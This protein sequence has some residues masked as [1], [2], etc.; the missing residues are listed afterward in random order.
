ML[1]ISALLRTAVIGTF[2]VAF[3]AGKFSL[4]R[5]LPF[6]SSVEPRVAFTVLCIIS[7][8]LLS[9]F[10]RVRPALDMRT[11]AVIGAA[12]AL[13][14]F[15]LAHLFAKGKPSVFGHYGLDLTLVC[16]QLA[17][18]PFVIRSKQ[19]LL[20]LV[21]MT[22]ALAF[23]LILA[24]VLVVDDRPLGWLP[25]ATSITF[26][27]IEFL[28]ACGAMLAFAWETKPRL[29]AVH[30]AIAI[31]CVFA[32][33]SSQAK[34]AIVF[35]VAVLGYWLFTFA[36]VGRARLAAVSLGVVIA[37]AAL[38]GLSTNRWVAAARW[39]TVGSITS[40]PKVTQSIGLPQLTKPQVEER[41]EGPS[42]LV[43]DPKAATDQDKLDMEDIEIIQDR[44]Q[45]TKLF[46]A[47]FGLWLEAKLLGSGFGSYSVRLRNSNSDGFEFAD[48]PHSIALEMLVVAG[49]IGGALWGMSVF[50]G[51]VA[52]HQLVRDD[53]TMIFMAGYP[54]SVL[55]SALF[56]GDTF[57]FRG[58]YFVVLAMTC[59]VAGSG[60]KQVSWQGSRLH[61]A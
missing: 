51:F 7:I 45:R 32:T 27:R 34:I 1:S 2:V 49:L 55:I 9:R 46:R 50:V 42:S 16:V 6:G 56:A 38:Y 57:D 37:A 17:L 15:L 8:G 59:A 36:V 29:K 12:L 48:H 26:Y 13:H 39:S 18:V 24:A 58:F 40:A 5:V 22:E 47:A 53:V 44:T 10:E 3:L 41:R 4:G 25:F 31:M 19:D 61:T 21:Y 35:V 43:W 54:L 52:V 11:I 23:A 33:V 20:V 30:L 14:L 28:A 60:A